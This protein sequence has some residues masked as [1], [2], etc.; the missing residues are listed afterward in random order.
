[1]GDRQYVIFH[2]IDIKQTNALKIASLDVGTLRGRSSEVVETMS[3]RG[4]A[5]CCIQQCR[6]R[7][8]LTRMIDS[9]DSRYKCFCIGNELGAGGVGVLLAEKW[10]DK[11]FDVKRVSD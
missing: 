5:L 6:W 8:V 2:D 1:M 3:R 7:G 4:I 9:K 10:I 11:V